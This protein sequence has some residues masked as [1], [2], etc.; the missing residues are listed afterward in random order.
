[1]E[2]YI[3][4][5]TSWITML[6]SL[7]HKQWALKSE[8][9][10]IS[11]GFGPRCRRSGSRRLRRVCLNAS[12]SSCSH[13]RRILR[14]VIERQRPLDPWNA[15]LFRIRR[16]RWSR[17]ST[18][19]AG[20]A[21]PRKWRWRHEK[22]QGWSQTRWCSRQIEVIRSRR[23]RWKGSW[24]AWNRWQSHAWLLRNKKI[25]VFNSTV[26]GTVFK[27]IASSLTPP[28]TCFAC[29]LPHLTVNRRPRSMSLLKLFSAATSAADL[30]VYW[31][32]AHCCLATT[33]MFLISPYW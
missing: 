29:D 20:R 2:F 6:L 18:E 31:T 25:L 3:N 12:D 33:V 24:K 8:T 16:G 30:V 27:T 32:K 13:A 11:R 23:R 19:R 10:L 28:A 7:F 14:W 21:V 17:L 5:S 1:M 15:R 4:V 26:Y 9:E 22:R